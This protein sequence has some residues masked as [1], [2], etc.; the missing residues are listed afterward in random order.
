MIQA[1]PI[2][3]SFSANRLDIPFIDP[4][5]AC[6]DYIV[7]QILCKKTVLTYLNAL[8]T[9]A[10]I[11]ISNMPI[12]RYDI[13]IDLDDLD[14]LSLNALEFRDGP[15]SFVNN[16]IETG[17]DYLRIDK[18]LGG[19]TSHNTGLG[20]WQSIDLTVTI[21]PSCDRYGEVGGE[22]VLKPFAL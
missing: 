10:G 22:H 8:T 15:G 19:V 17:I 21:L 12:F 16:I 20:T 14:K 3:K 11:T 18:L 13:D 4:V 7:P 6:I 5:V 9:D 1:D 2:I